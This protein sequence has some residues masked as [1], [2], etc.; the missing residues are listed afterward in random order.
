MNLKSRLKEGFTLVEVMVSMLIFLVAGMGLLPLLVGNLQVSRDNSLFGQARRLAGAAMA[1]MQVIDY[2]ELAMTP[3][4]PSRYGPIE[5][6]R[7]IEP[8]QPQP[9][10]TRLTVLARWEQVG[11]QHSYRLQSVRAKP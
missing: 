11:R 2:T 7:S 9:G 6:Q 4:T 10:L 8:G 5:L 3:E 1:G